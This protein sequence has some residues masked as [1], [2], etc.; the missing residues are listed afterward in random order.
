MKIFNLPP[1]ALV[2]IVVLLTFSIASWVHRDKTVA[3]NPVLFIALVMMSGAGI[4]TTCI[5]LGM[6]PTLMPAGDM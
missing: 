1:S 3:I 4:F 5:F 2:T 6:F